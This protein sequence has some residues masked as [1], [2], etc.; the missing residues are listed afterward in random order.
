MGQEEISFF[1]VHLTIKKPMAEICHR[2]LNHRNFSAGYSRATTAIALA[3]SLMVSLPFFAAAENATGLIVSGA[4]KVLC[5]SIAGAVNNWPFAL[6]AFAPLR[7]T[8]NSASSL[9]LTFTSAR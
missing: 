4:A 7:S 9:G 5:A 3:G 1:N 8:L 2:L 6:C